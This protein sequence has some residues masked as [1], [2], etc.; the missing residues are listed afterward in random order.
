MQLESWPDLDQAELER[1]VSWLQINQILGLVRFE[2]VWENVG[3]CISMYT[4]P[5][6]K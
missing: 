2:V 4:I 6:T 5:P 1:L 3:Q